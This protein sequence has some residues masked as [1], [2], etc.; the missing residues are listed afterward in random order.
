[1]AALGDTLFPVTS[2]AAGFAR[3]FDPSANLFV[4][5]RIWHPLIAAGAGAV[6]ALLCAIGGVICRGTAPVI[7][8]A[9]ADG[10]PTRLRRH[11]SGSCSPRWERNWFTCC[12]PICCGFAGV[13]SAGEAAGLRAEHSSWSRQKE[14]S[15]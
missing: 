1:M 6:G 10:R 12:W 2:L 9:G 3:D 11:Q 14:E 8:R 13:L 7:R 15:R 5:L 4:R